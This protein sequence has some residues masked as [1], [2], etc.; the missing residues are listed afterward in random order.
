MQG[1]DTECS[2]QHCF[3]GRLGSPAGKV[4]FASELA[5]LVS[6]KQRL[7]VRLKAILSNFSFSTEYMREALGSVFR[8]GV[9]LSTQ[10][11]ALTPV[12]NIMVSS[13]C[14]CWFF[15]RLLGETGG[16]L[17]VCLSCTC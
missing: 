17:W 12:A 8:Q 11:G 10:A 6:Q 4:I 3:S 2:E 7:H 15:F 1:G 5:V 9:K 14:S 16:T 13:R